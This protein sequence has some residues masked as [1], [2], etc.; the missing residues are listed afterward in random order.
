MK[1]GW[2]SAIRD[3]LVEIGNERKRSR[4]MLAIGL[5]LLASL[6]YACAGIFAQRG[7]HQ[8]PTPWGAWITLVVNS[9]FL[10]LLHLLVSPEAPIFISANLIF[11]FIGFFV[12]GLTRVLN[13]RGIR[14]LGASV[15]STVINSTPMFATA[16]AVIFLGERPGLVVLSGLGVIVGGLTAISW[17]GG[18]GWWSQLELF[19]PLLAAVFFAGKDVL[20]RWG[21]GITGQPILA[22][23]I[24]SITGTV[25]V[26]FLLSWIQGDRFRLPPPRIFFWFAI[27]GLFTGGSFVFQYLALFIENVSIVSPIVNTYSVFVLVLAPL[28][29]RG[30]ERVTLRKVIGA[31]GV[32]AGVALISIGRS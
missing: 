8:L 27:S 13:F 29:A 5:S 21:M 14:T 2:I 7:L 25:E 1:F 28:L 3:N 23:A 10:W 16:L 31:V 12:P 26:Y 4:I 24:A 9:L 6:C 19:Y 22:V 11:V 32:V 20:A 18:R 30:I 17:G 15:T